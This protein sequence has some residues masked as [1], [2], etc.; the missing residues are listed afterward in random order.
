MI[1]CHRKKGTD[2]IRRLKGN[3]ARVSTSATSPTTMRLSTEIWIALAIIIAPYAVYG[4]NIA[5][6]GA[7]ISSL[8]MLE[9]KGQ[10]YKTTA[11]ATTPLEKILASSGVNSVRQRV[12][13]N[14]SDG[15]YNLD[16][17][18]RLAKRVK[19]AGMSVYLD[20]HLSDTWADPG[21][22]VRPPTLITCSS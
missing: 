21:H 11:G 10:T 9:G 8:L 22:Q 3:A 15:N 2:S 6:K 13:V 7:D 1:M 17:N 5:F 20:L 18:L 19:A 14:P 4:D 12:W 16:Y